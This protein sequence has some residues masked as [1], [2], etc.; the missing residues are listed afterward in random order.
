MKKRIAVVALFLVSLFIASTS[1]ASAEDLVGGMFE[2]A[3]RGLVDVL[4]G[5]V[6]LPTQ[7]IK[8]YNEG[9]MDDES[10]KVLGVVVGVFDGIGHSAGRTFSGFKDL[11]G[12]WTA[13]PVDNEG[14]G[15]PLDSEYAWEKGEP[16]NCFDPNI[17]EGAIKPMGQKLVRGAVNSLFGIVEL[18]GQIMKGTS[19]GALDLGITK[20]VWYWFSREWYGFNDIFTMTL[21][22]HIDEKGLAFDEEWPWDAFQ[23][24]IQ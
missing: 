21:P 2:K 11:C 7:I 8:G 12:F 16:Y 4:T 10:R 6:E 23:T 5:W 14:V 17:T 15:I 20:G 19:E 9:F 18:P 24:S 13:N 22:N 1:Y 3:K